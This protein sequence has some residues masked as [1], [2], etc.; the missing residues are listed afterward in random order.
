[1]HKV[2]EDWEIL[3]HRTKLAPPGLEI[4]DRDFDEFEE[5]RTFF[6]G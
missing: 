1:V 6:E 4:E 3:L 5:V 2:I